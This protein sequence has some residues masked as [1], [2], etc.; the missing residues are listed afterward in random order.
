[1]SAI[2]FPLTDM[3]ATIGIAD[4]VF[5]LVS[6]QELGGRQANGVTQGIDFGSALWLATYTTENLR[7][8]DAVDYEAMLRSLDGVIGTFEAIDLRR[9][10]PRQYRDGSASDGVLQT[11]NENNKAISLSGLNPGQVVSRGDYLSWDYGGNRA[12]VQSMQ[13]IAADVDGVTAEFEIRP[14]LRE[15][16]GN[17]GTN[18]NVKAPRGVFRLLPG[19]VTPRQVNGKFGVLTFQAGQVIL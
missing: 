19:S 17:V 5:D 2:I 14:H 9:S 10:T 13:T 15:G 12:L 1:M 4:Q 7:N 11:A 18:V 8:D 16:S 3:F 6:R